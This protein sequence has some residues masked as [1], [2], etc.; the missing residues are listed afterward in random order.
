MNKENYNRREFF[1]LSFIGLFITPF[2]LQCKQKAK[3]LLINLTGTNH[4]L[5]HRL[6]SKNFPEVSGIK[7]VKYLI[8]GG[9]ISGLSA[10]RQLI[11]KGITDFALLEMSDEIGGNASSG[12][13]NI[14]SYPRG[15]HYLPLPDKENKELL[16]FL[17]ESNIII[18]YKEGIP[19]YDEEQ[20]SFAP[21]ERLFIN[22]SW[23]EGLIPKS[24]R[25]KDSELEF[26]R[27][28]KEMD[29]FRNM[30]GA[31]GKFFF[32]IPFSFISLDTTLQSLDKLTMK[33]WLIKNNF[34]AEELLWYV[35]YCCKDDYGLGIDSV[36]AWAGIH[37]FASRKNN[38]NLYATDAVLTWPEGNARLAAHLKKRCINH[39][40]KNHLAYKVGLE[41][42]KVHVHAFNSKNNQSTLIKSEKV[43][44]SSPQFINKY[45][46]KDRHVFTK[47]FN[48][49]PWIVATF[50][51]NS[52]L[53]DSE[54]P[55]SWDNVIYKGKGL[56]YIYNQNQNLNQINDKK[57][58]SYY[59]CLSGPDLNLERK[60][61]FNK[62]ENYWRNYILN[63]LKKAHPDIE[64]FIENM[65]IYRIGHGMIAPVPGF[66][67]GKE[68]KEASKT[69]NDKIYFA[70]TDLT[71]YS[72]FEEAFQQGINAANQLLK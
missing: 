31:D 22:N 65:E 62:T 14:S 51:V 63:D 45:L 47:N 55:L 49:S 4:I 12:R 29:I 21:H 13:N 70:H 39:I 3:K 43:I 41:K 36:S 42:D 9:G 66:I 27:F 16:N 61:L 50:T 7:E 56:G 52:A 2:L 54:F 8:I 10:A 30:K 44:V 11:S 35:D 64:N 46:I 34:S 59:L 38:A 33:D 37:Y 26:K 32:A 5:G 72:L 1:K 25:S 71:G 53:H 48:Y 67:F 68:K 23:Q 6:W 24:T 69:I 28:L 15:A 18:N 60:K 19:V 58:I 57:V 17:Y 40:Y 20:L